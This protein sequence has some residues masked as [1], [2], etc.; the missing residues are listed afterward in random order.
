MSTI[1]TGDRVRVNR[2]KYNWTPPYVTRVT[3]I[4][5]NSL[6]TTIYVM[7]SG[8]HLGRAEFEKY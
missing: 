2:S 6:G 5:T 1:N 7:E 8:A 4:T 3:A